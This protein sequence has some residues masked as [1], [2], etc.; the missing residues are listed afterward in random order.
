MV[1]T[2]GL[3]AAGVPPAAGAP[4]PGDTLKPFS[5]T[6]LDGPTRRWIPG[7][8][9]VISFCAFWCDTWKEHGKR[10]ARADR[11]LSGLPVDFLTVSIDGRWADVARGKIGGIVLLDAGRTLTAELEVDRI[12]YTVVVET[13]GRVTFA[14]HGIIRSAD[15]VGAVRAALNGAAASAGPI[16]LTFDDFPSKDSALDDAL[17]DA[18]RAQ[19][20]QAAFFCVCNRLSGSADIVRRASREGHSLQIHCWDHQSAEMNLPKCARALEALGINPPILYRPPGKSG[21]RRLNGETLPETV[22]NPYDF[23]RPGESEITRR[24]LL[25]IKPGSVILLHAGVS[26]TVDALP[27]IV[28]G[29]RAGGFSFDLPR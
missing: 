8:V 26:Q 14:R 27:E 10:I 21:C 24:V 25:A 18:L 3:L 13:T 11:A 15:V 4:L 1:L 22:V 17:L 6:S 23:A 29:A 20:V 19:G 5:L 28:R 2:A 12:P 7:R 16:Y 9:T